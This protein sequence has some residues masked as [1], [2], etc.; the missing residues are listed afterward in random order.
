MAT[1]ATTAHEVEYYLE[2]PWTL[3][4]KHETDPIDGKIFVAG[5]LEWPGV[6]SHAPSYNKAIENIQEALALAISMAL[7]TG[8]TIPEPD[9]VKRFKGAIAYR[10][11][12]ERHF[13]LAQTAR[14]R[15]LSLSQLIDLC[16][17]EFIANGS[18]E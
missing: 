13:L 17:D 16:I 7:Q 1:E 10:T 15:N 9:H 8:D 18:K 3:T 12:P 2:L 11:S 4:I 5:V 14:R 6:S